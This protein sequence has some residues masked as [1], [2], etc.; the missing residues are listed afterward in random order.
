MQPEEPGSQLS[1]A[2]AASS[3]WQAM[4]FAGIATVILGLVRAFDGREPYRVFMQRHAASESQASQG[5][6]APNS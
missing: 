2:F 6:P 1:P 5:Q 4:V 3:G